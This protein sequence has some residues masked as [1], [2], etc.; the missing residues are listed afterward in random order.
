M[1]QAK[2]QMNLGAFLYN[3]GH[4]FAAWRYSG[5]KTDGVIDM[6]FYKRLGA[7]A[8]RG[9]L[10]MLFLADT[11]SIPHLKDAETNVSFVY[12]EAT[13]VLAALSAVTEYVG[14]AATVSTTFNEPYNVARRF[15]TI[16]HLSGGRA[17]WNVVTSTK[18]AE[19]LNFGKEILLEHSLR[20]ERAKEFL[21]VVTA[22]WDS[23]EDEA[24][25]F[26]KDTGIFA[27]TERIHAISHRGAAFSVE[28]PL[29]IPRSP[30]G[31][32]VIIEA[33]T[34]PSG[35][36][37]AAQT[38]EVV[39]TACEDK[40][41]GKAFYSK[42]KALL[43]EYGRSEDDLK[44]MPGVLTFIG[45]TE[46]EAKEKEAAFND[47]V[48]PK[49]GVVHLSRLLNFD[50]SGYPLDG[51]LP[52]ISEQGNTSRAL[53]I[54]DMAR[55]QGLTVRELSLHFAIA[56]GHLVIRGTAEQI[57]DQLEDWFVSRACDGFN[58]MPPYLPRGLDEFVDQVVPL[59]QQRGIFRTEYSG[60]TLRDHLGLKRPANRFSGTNAAQR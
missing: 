30:Q 34:S 29:N 51:P 48:L 54:I 53:M 13:S 46:E 2:R 43:P 59:L 45:E 58:V 31:R 60:R 28:G 44:V 40:E 3:F 27:D 26:N 33:G 55:K 22:L 11:V 35:Q 7:T 49:A 8:E 25:L 47:L 12:P 18:Q 17:A 5:T 32:P 16:D 41:E 15:S 20:Y 19:A 6:E 21:D 39:F 24:L 10:D 56:R 4:H 14:L 52:D 42:L 37:L 9:K 23:W 1:S 36:R 57:A 38:A 50:L